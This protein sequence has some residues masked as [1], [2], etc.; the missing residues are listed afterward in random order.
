MDEYNIPLGDMQDILH[1]LDKTCTEV[2][3]RM[4]KEVGVSRSLSTSAIKRGD[5]SPK[6]RAF[7]T[8]L[9]P[10]T[11]TKKQRIV[12]TSSLASASATATPQTRT[13]STPSN[14][15]PLRQYGSA[16]SIR[17]SSISTA[18]QSKEPSPS[19]SPSKS[20]AV[21]PR[22]RD[23]N[24]RLN[25][26]AIEDD[27]GS[28]DDDLPPSPTKGRTPKAAWAG[29]SKRASQTVLKTPRRRDADESD[30][31]DSAMDLDALVATV[32]TAYEAQLAN[33]RCPRHSRRPFA[34][35]DFYTRRD[36]RVARE[37]ELCEDNFEVMVKTLGYPYGQPVSTS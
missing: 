6:K 33:S 9:L 14:V 20:A 37:W 28:E 30:V 5:E 21:T 16:R 8:S 15:T 24:E 35:R 17:T 3:E 27:E 10:K 2:Q 18:T 4:D 1:A 31:G 34:D 22:T 29:S 36:P 12:G 13:Y 11:P 19:K 7:D 26:L 23:V 25:R 32:D